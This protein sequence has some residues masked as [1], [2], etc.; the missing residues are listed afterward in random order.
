MAT[1][2]TRLGATKPASSENIDVTI[3]GTDFDLFDAAVAATVGLSAS[4]PASAFSGRLWYSSD[5]AKL[6]V[7]SAASAS[8]AASWQDAV[9]NALLSNVILGGSV[10]ASAGS[11]DITRSAG[12]T[13]AFSSRVSGDTQPRWEMLAGGSAYWG[14]GAGAVDTNLYRS[15][16]DT[17]KTDDS[18]IVGGGVTSVG[19]ISAS[20]TLTVGGAA[21]LNGGLT[22]AVKGQVSYVRKAATTGRAST[23]ALADDPHLTFTLAASGVYE[24]R[25]YMA[26]TGAT[27]GDFKTAW[28]VTG[29]A[30]GGSHTTRSTKGPT[31]TVTDS[32]SV[33][34]YRTSRHSLATA[35][36]YGV[37]A[38][39]QSAIEEHF[40]L[41]TLPGSGA[42]TLQWAQNSSNATSTTLTSD[43]WAVLTR[44][45]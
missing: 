45:A 41:D 26:V 14:S 36:P 3:L 6:F 17:L 34:T 30:S 35:A 7:N 39:V 2:T 23:T 8:T 40:L 13:I 5:S 25:C 16:A 15:A 27:A 19:N 31:T 22:V 42:V 9:A 11:F 28:N 38:I 43:S 33:G 20:T 32:T 1:L 44:L 29:P 24:M 37:D 10:S 18:L 4:R 21:S 12:P